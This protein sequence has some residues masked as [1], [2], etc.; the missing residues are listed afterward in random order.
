MRIN[1]KFA[2]KAQGV[3]NRPALFPMNKNIYLDHA[4]STETYPEVINALENL[5]K[6]HFAN[7]S[8][9]HTLGRKSRS[10]IDEARN[11]IE[12]IF[13]TT[14]KNVIF[15]S[16]GTES[17]H[18]AIIGS[19]LA[20]KK[21]GRTKQKILISPLSHACIWSTIQFLSDYFGVQTELIPLN[22]QGFFETKKMT[23]EWINQFDIIIAEHGNSEI[24]LIQPI[25]EIGRILDQLEAANKQRPILI[26]D[27][28][29]S[30]ITE[31]V[32][33]ETLKADIITL[34]G[35]KFGALKGTGIIIK[36]NHIPLTPMIH[37]SQEMGYRGGTENI[38]GIFSLGKALEIHTKKREKLCK[39]FLNLHTFLRQYF[40][41]HF[42]GCHITTPTLHFLP[43]TFHF[44]L[45][46]G[47]EGHDF[48]IKCDLEGLCISSGS[49][50]SSG[51]VGSSRVLE[52]LGL[53]KNE[54]KRGVRISLGRNTTLKNLQ[55]AVKIF[56]KYI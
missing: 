41:K 48:V 25:K 18:L 14:A 23:P 55:E 11:T 1:N 7:P 30:I 15:T 3:Y 36:K 46:K 40:E 35:S 6:E 20:Q 53:S 21:Q 47:K 12:K 5:A 28:A 29:A 44:V 17:I 34:A 16:S 51:S 32:N 42:P 39:H 31:A 27:C 4:A 13:N 56:D 9:I 8:S 10:I 49:A 43:H 26:A 38:L 50:C 19:Y 22:T 37:G 54:A 33:T 24:G 45:P 52:N 2:H